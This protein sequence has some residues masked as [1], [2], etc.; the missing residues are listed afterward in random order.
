MD[1]PPHLETRQGNCR[2]CRHARHRC[3]PRQIARRE[4]QPFC[5]CP[6]LFGRHAKKGCLRRSRE[7]IIV[8][9][10]K[11][12]VKKGKYRCTDAGNENAGC[13]IFD[14]EREQKFKEIFSVR[15]RFD[16][17]LHRF[18]SIQLFDILRSTKND[19]M[20]NILNAASSH[21]PRGTRPGAFPETNIARSFSDPKESLNRR[22]RTQDGLMDILDH[23]PA[24]RRIL[25]L[26]I[27][28][29]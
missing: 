4:R 29:Q 17:S 25:V 13:I 20:R 12:F 24:S 15:Y 3:T 16:F 19:K 28:C 5:I 22:S 21:R 14:C 8:Y 2:L 23:F 6:F 26:K 1:I 27:F 11:V 18:E 7:A 9:E 10:Y